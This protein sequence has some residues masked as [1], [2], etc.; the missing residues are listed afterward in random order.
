MDRNKEEE[1]CELEERLFYAII[2]FQ[3]KK[4]EVMWGKEKKEWKKVMVI[5]KDKE[6]EFLKQNMWKI[7]GRYVEDTE[8]G[9]AI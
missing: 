7:K 3:E 5:W 4:V 9:K 6:K 1:E 8:A 2:K